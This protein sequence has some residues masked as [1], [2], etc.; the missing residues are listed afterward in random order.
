MY[1]VCYMLC[2]I[3]RKCLMMNFLHQRKRSKSNSNMS[4][5]LII[6]KNALAKFR[7]SA[8]VHISLLTELGGIPYTFLN[9]LLK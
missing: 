9:A 6:N 2:V 8:F 7:Q 1:Q 4:N 3:I 5:S